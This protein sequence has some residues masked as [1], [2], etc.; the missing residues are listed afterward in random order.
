MPTNDDLMD[1]G[2]SA[3][4]IGDLE[5]AV[6]YFRQVVEQDPQFQD[7]WHA[8]AMAL[9]KLDRYVEAI[10]AGRRAAQIDPNN[11]FVWS[12]LSLAYNA[13][14]QKA[15]AE[16]AGAKARIISWGGKVKLDVDSSGSDSASHAN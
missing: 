12:S 6:K 14:Q 2:N 8:L 11:Q 10:E 13:N 9:Y 4:A 3:L 7:G 1:E 15:E 5:Q 16:A